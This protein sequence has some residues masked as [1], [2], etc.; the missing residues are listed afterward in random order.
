MVNSFAQSNQQLITFQRTSGISFKSLNKYAS[1]N[2]A[3]N[4]NS[5]IE[6]TAQSMQRVAQN[7]WDIRM[8]RG[9]ISPYQELA[10]VGGKAFNPMGMSVEQVIESV[11]EAIKGVDDL[12]ATNII[13]RMGFAPD[14]LLMLRMSREELEKIND[15]FLSP[16][17]REA[18]NKYALELKKT[19]LEFDKLGQIITLDLAKPFIQLAKILQRLSKL[20]YIG[21]VRPIQVAFKFISDLIKTLTSGINNLITSFVKAHQ[22]LKPIFDILKMLAELIILPLEDLFVYLSGGDSLVG[23]G[24]DAIEGIFQDLD[25]KFE[26]SGIKKFF[27]CIEDGIKNL[28]TLSLPN[29]LIGLFTG[30]WIPVVADLIKMLSPSVSMVAPPIDT[31]Y[32]SYAGNKNWNTN[33]NF[34]ITTNQ[35]MEIV[36][37]NLINK[38]MP[39]QV[40]YGIRAV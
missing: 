35:P 29:W 8:G 10:F 17:Q 1:A 3:V 4:F 20:L 33:N 28:A 18:M 24:L 2:A 7:L 6:G 11:R 40:Q 13:T 27:K 32:V 16:Q 34:S 26:E 37:D 23:R 19:K 14:D 30:N 36:A 12:Q 5:T 9:D 39:T 38:F 31:N 22:E 25:A 21:I 15:M